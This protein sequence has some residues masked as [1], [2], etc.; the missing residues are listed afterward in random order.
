MRRSWLVTWAVHMRAFDNTRVYSDAPPEQ[1]GTLW[2]CFT[3]REG[4]RLFIVNLAHARS[5]VELD[6]DAAVLAYE[7][8]HA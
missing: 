3:E 4:G 8:D 2:P 6:E 5:I 7:A 1:T